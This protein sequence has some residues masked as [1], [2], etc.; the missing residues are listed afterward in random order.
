VR[1]T[2]GLEER[3]EPLDHL[4]ICLDRPRRRQVV[5]RRALVPER[6][7]DDHDVAEGEIV[8][9]CPAPAARHDGP[10]A[11]LHHLLKKPHRQRRPQ[12]RLEERQA[13]PSVLDLPDIMLAVLSGELGDETSR[14]FASDT[15]DDVA[16]EARHADVRHV[17]PLA[18]TRAE[19]RG[20]FDHRP[21]VG[22]ELGEGN[23][24]HDGAA[25]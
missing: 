4:R 7:R 14:P 20:G 11:A 23:A 13:R 24:S 16:E 22:V 8:G 10:A 19:M 12:P 18:V 21:P 25:M 6:S 1:H 15:T 5:E 17:R 2:P 9:Q 3:L